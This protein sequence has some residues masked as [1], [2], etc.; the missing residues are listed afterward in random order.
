MRLLVGVAAVLG[1]GAAAAAQTLEEL[2]DQLRRDL[3]N[4]NYSAL[5]GTMAGLTGDGQ[6]SLGTLRAEDADDEW[7]FF[8]L[9]WRRDFEVGDGWPRFRVEASIG[10]SKADLTTD[11]LWEGLLPGLETGARATYEV[12]AGDAGVGPVVPLPG[13]FTLQPLLHVGLAYLENDADYWG[14]G[15]AVSQVL[16]DGI[17][18]GWE[19]VEVS[20][21]GSL[22]LQYDGWRTGGTAWVPELRYDVRTCEPVESED[23]SR[24]ESTTQ[25]W[26][27]AHFGGSGPLDRSA[28]DG[29]Q[30]SVGLGYQRLLSGAHSI[31]GFDDFF[32]LGAGLRWPVPEWVPLLS[33][34]T[35]HGAVQIG[36][37]VRGWSLGFGVAF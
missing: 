11:D 1:V 20:Y 22:A 35:L 3:R 4:S 26:M 33:A 2:R 32:E 8:T 15:A 16:L 19:Q 9:P 30:W 28:P 29:W 12:W 23:P 27:S 34:A 24:D 37:D 25:Q 18:F 17:L 5:L 36:D 31:L 14:P 7:S 6:M 10:W 21:G 13:E